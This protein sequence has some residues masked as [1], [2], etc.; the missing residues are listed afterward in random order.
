MTGL[1]LFA[2]VLLLYA[3]VSQGLAGTI[4]SPALAFC[5]S[6]LVIGFAGGADIRPQDLES[7]P[8]EAVL[9]LA[10]LALA[11]VLFADSAALGLQ[12]LRR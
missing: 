5:L 7:G 2:V 9:L 1:G 8:R 3:L 4:V 11:L 6:G 12:R 10:E